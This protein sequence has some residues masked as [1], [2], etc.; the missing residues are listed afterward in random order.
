M[1]SKPKLIRLGNELIEEGEKQARKLGLN[2][3]EYIR[4]IIKLDA[5]TNIIRK[6]Q[7]K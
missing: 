6:L 7:G 2:F 3:S 5:A 4:L 1:E